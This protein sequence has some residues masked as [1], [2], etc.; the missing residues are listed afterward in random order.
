MVPDQLINFPERLMVRLI[1]FASMWRSQYWDMNPEKTEKPEKIINSSFKP[2]WIWCTSCIYIAF[3]AVF[4]EA[5]VLTHRLAVYGPHTKMNG[6]SNIEQ[7][8]KAT[9]GPHDINT[10]IVVP[11]GMQNTVKM[12]ALNY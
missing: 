1:V 3:V 10:N 7:H 11:K 2:K 12:P 5:Q 8:V 9:K 6:E 4:N